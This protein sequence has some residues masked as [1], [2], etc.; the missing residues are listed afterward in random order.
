M[1]SNINT[2]TIDLT[3]PVS[4]VDNSTQGFRDNWS[5]IKNAFDT[6]RDEISDLQLHAFVGTITSLTV[7]GPTVLTTATVS[8]LLAT[9]ATVTTAVVDSLHVTTATVGHITNYPGGSDILVDSAL[10]VWPIATS[11]RDVLSPQVGAII[12]N[13]TSGTFQGYTSGGWVHFVTTSTV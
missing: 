1:A 8:N 3:Y 13:I 7:N 2:G 5:A 12:Y 9:T 6:A 11:I 10:R 4:G